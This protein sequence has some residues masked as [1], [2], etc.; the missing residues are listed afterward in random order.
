VSRTPVREALFRLRRE[1]C[2]EVEAKTGGFVRSI[3]FDTVDQLYD[4]RV[5]KFR[6]VQ[7]HGSSGSGLS[8]LPA[9]GA[10]HVCP[11]DAV[12][13]QP[14]AQIRVVSRV[15]EAS[16]RVRMAS[17]A[18]CFPRGRPGPPLSD[19]QAA[20]RQDAMAPAALRVDQLNSRMTN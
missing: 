17:L 12:L 15:A 19:P 9:L 16:L 6:E 4:L 13:D 3:D 1:G 20:P 8:L 18:P 14:T 10:D 2:L 5:R 11:S 7:G